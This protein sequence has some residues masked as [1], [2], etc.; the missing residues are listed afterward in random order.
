MSTTSNAEGVLPAL[1]IL[2]GHQANAYWSGLFGHDG[3]TLD[4]LADQAPL[5]AALEEVFGP[6]DVQH[7]HDVFVRHSDA[8]GEAYLREREATEERLSVWLHDGDHG[9]ATAVLRAL[10]RQLVHLHWQRLFTANRRD[11]EVVRQMS[12]RFTERLHEIDAYLIKPVATA[13]FD[14]AE[15][16]RARMSDAYERDPAALKR[17]L[18]VNVAPTRR[19]PGLGAVTGAVA[20]AMAG[21]VARTAVRVTLWEGIRRLFFGR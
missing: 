4:A 2:A 8:L 16:E 9:A 12:A 18:G 7:F 1:A 20:G 11:P 10:A 3:S 5:A 6:T 14:E 15:A 17:D 21:E 19:G 13:F